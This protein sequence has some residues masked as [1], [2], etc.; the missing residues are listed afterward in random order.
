[1]PFNEIT[2]RL[3][4]TPGLDARYRIGREIGEVFEEGEDFD[5][6][7]LAIELADPSQGEAFIAAIRD[8]LQHIEDAT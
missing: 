6:Y 4:P 5:G 1:M 2:G 7:A 3:T 8:G